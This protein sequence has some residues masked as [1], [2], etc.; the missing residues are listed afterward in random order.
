VAPIPTTQRIREKIRHWRSRAEEF[1][2]M[3]DCSATA[4][5]KDAYVILARNCDEMAD[6]IELRS[7]E[8][9]L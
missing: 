4:S 9:A 1:R 7:S 8:D 6:S 5:V 3:G 2:A